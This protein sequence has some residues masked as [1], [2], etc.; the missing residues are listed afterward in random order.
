MAAPADRVFEQINDLRKSPDWSPFIKLDKQIKYSFDGPQTGVGAVYRWS[1][2]DEVGEGSMTIVESQ[3]NELVRM[4]LQFIRPM[5]DTAEAVF[6]LQPAGDRINVTWTMNGT[7]SFVEKAFCLFMDLDK[8]IGDK[9]TEG[10]TDLKKIVEA[11]P[12][13]A[14]EKGLQ[15]PAP[16]DGGQPPSNQSNTKSE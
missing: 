13:D 15:N 1:G 7:N 3:P 14:Q 16:L 9:F 12:A 5:E 2:N 6:T 8:M 10:L 4:K 11:P